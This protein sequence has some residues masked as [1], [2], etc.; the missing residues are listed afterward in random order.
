MADNQPQMPQPNPKL[1]TLK[2]MLG[3]WELHG[4]TT[5]APEDNV[6]GK[7]VISE[8]P[9]GFFYKQEVEIDFAGMV[10]VRGIEIIGYDEE[11]DALVSLVYSNMSP[12]PVKYRW[13]LNG[14]D[15]EIHMYAGATMHATMSDDENSF[16]G[17]WAP[18]PGHENDPGNVP[19]T[20]GGHRVK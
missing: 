2:P 15:L 10:Q 12:K 3:T 17:A 6:K 8:L 1:A 7:A 4:R 11:E 19:Y 5:G 16:E 9:G 20:F 14:K 13:K 18:D